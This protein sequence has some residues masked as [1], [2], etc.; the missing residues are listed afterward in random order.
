MTGNSSNPAEEETVA[1]RTYS[2][3]SDCKSGEFGEFFGGI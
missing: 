1:S 2:T 3:P